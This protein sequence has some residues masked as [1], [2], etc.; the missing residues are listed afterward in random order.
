MLRTRLL[1]GL[2]RRLK[3]RSS[4]HAYAISPAV[5]ASV[6]KDGVVF[7]H[8]SKGAVFSAN[9]VGSSMWQA[10]C[11]GQTVDEMTVAIS[12]EYDAPAEIVGRDAAN[13]VRDLVAE[14][15]LVRC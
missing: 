5:K 10:I 3:A 7:L 1:A 8:S 14:G 13:F 4:D 9:R 11:A 2:Q 15:I 6:H 12:R